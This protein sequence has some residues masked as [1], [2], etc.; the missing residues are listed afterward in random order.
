M[1]DHRPAAGSLALYKIRPALVTAVSDKIDITLEGGKSKRVRP[2]DISILHPGPLKSLGD[3]GEPDGDVDEAWALLEGA[4]THLEELAELAFGDYTPSTAWAAWQLVADGLYFEG[5]PQSIVTRT[6]S[7]ISE[8][9]AQQEAKEAAE[10][11]WESFIGRLKSRQLAESDRERLVEVERLALKVNDKS[12][13]LQALG[14]QESPENAHRMLVDV[15]YWDVSRN[16]YPARQSLVETDPDL[17]V[18]EMPPQERLDLTH[19]PAYAIDDEGSDDPDD[20]ISLDGDRIW[21]HVADVAALVPVDS[22]LDIEA[23]ARAANLYIPERI[24]HMLPPAIT[25]VL[26]LGL[27]EVS[28]ALSFGF[29]LDETGEPRDLQIA[30]SQVRV[31]RHSYS[32]INGRMD[33][34]PFAS[35]QKMAETYRARRKAA[36]SASIDLPEVSVRAGAEGIK[37]KPLDR[38]HSRQMVTD[39][40]LMVGEAVARYAIEQNIP[41]PFATQPPPEKPAEPQGMAEMC[42]YRR[43]MRP[44]KSK[45]LEE[46]HSGLGLEA[47]TRATSPLRR[48]LDLV[49]HQQL[50]AHLAGQTLLS[51]SEISERIGATDVTGGAI[52]RAERLSNTHWKL[53]FLKE[54]PKW[55]G[56]AIVV[57]MNDQRAT[58]VIPELA[59]ETKVRV[60]R[61]L[62]LNEEVK[63]AVREVDLADLTVWF[64]VIE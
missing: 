4:E 34:E 61:D 40:M 58:L 55:Q 21:V 36:G 19:L 7:Q 62:P 47:Y 32:E 56:G 15:G 64:R 27:Q 26:G 57:E 51:V 6:E 1:P 28:P 53:L 31:S 63:V 8:D 42:A 30:P 25:G 39:A 17:P 29:R 12:Q 2:K 3:L 46:P 20:A 33:E 50:R 11:D 52:R 10:R 23:R 44:S 24:V 16:P 37:I 9:R 60:R 48:Y 41:L 49:T 13:I 45:T 18:P 54:N 14:H 35:L 43:Q 59:L 5:T 22:D 38:L